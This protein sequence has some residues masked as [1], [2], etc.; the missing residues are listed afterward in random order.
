MAQA[1]KRR[2]TAAAK[3]PADGAKTEQEGQSGA[4]LAGA[5]MEALQAKIGDYET[6]EKQ[7]YKRLM[8]DGQLVGYV[9]TSKRHALVQLEV[10]V[11]DEK[12]LK[13]AVDALALANEAR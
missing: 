8:K 9:R 12:G 5:L 2:R 10:P 7:A 4:E 6:V 3:A 11:R 1:N 13:R